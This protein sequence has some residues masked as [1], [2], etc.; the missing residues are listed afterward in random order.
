MRFLALTDVSR[1]RYR[2]GQEYNFFPQCNNYSPFSYMSKYVKITLFGVILMKTNARKIFYFLSLEWKHIIQNNSKN[3][4]AELQI[5]FS[6]IFI[7]YSCDHVLTTAQ[8]DPDMCNHLYFVFLC[9]LV[10]P[11]DISFLSWTLTWTLKAVSYSI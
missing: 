5:P 1:G 10:K 6:T 8:M 9:L 4:S 3:Y 11:G 2:N 7:S